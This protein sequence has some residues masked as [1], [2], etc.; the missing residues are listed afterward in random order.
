[1]MCH[2]CH[3]SCIHCWWIWISL[4][5]THSWVTKPH[6][7]NPIPVRIALKDDAWMVISTIVQLESRIWRV[8]HLHT[9]FYP[10]RI[11]SSNMIHTPILHNL[12]TINGIWL[13]YYNAHGDHVNICI[14]LVWN[15]YQW[16]FNCWPT[17]QKLHNIHSSYITE[18]RIHYWRG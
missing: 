8:G 18:I 11:P 15:E 12:T 10:Q 4:E 14:E 1:M 3:F 13:C 7:F 6:S 9:K 17:T 2:Y 16:L 5:K